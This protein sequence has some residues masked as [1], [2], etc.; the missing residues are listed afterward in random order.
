[1]SGPGD[2]GPA[3][4]LRADRALLAKSLGEWCYEGLL[5]PRV[6]PDGRYR[7]ELTDGVAYTFAATGGAFGWLRVDPGS[8]LREATG[9]LGQR[10]GAPA[11]DTRQL[12][13]DAAATIGI[14]ANT[15][16]EYLAELAATIAADASADAGRCERLRRLGHA[17]LEG[18]LTGHPWIVANKGR[19]GFAASDLMRYAPESRARFRLPWLAVQRGLAEFRA[20]PAL[21]EHALRQR[22]LD[23]ATRGR[24]ARRLTDLGLDPD[25]YVWLPVHPWQADRVID[26]RFGGELAQRRIVHLG[27]A[28]DEYLP[29]QS[30][31]T[32]T[33]M[34]AR[35][36]YD[37]KLPLSILNTSVWR[38]I[39]PH[40]T[41]G[42][43]VVTRWLHGLFTA[44]EY[45]SQQA[46]T[47][48]LGEVA[49]VTVAHPYLSTVAATPYR[50]L[51]TLGCIWREPVAAYADPDER[52]RS[53]AALLHVDADGRALLA[54]LVAGSGQSAERW[55][56]ALLEVLLTPILYVLYR[57]GLT[58]NPHGQNALIGYGPDE[59]PRRLY[60]KDFIDDVELSSGHLPERAPEPDGAVEMMPRKPPELIRQHVVDS[61]LIGFLRY[62]APLCARQVGLPEDRFWRLTR[63]AVIAVPQRFP[64]IA[65][66]SA[67]FDLL[68][69]RFDRYR[70]NADRLVVT[71]YGDAPIRHAIGASGTVPNPL[72]VASPDR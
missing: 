27:T 65:E 40:C 61:V 62:L 29:Q 18:W 22:E 64:E 10:N 37:V 55:V 25:S 8:V 30:I 72:Y 51:G 43:P 46:R 16:A 3:R 38:G 32:V 28:G 68:V 63:E 44:D 53:L 23:A 24:F 71:G 70:L 19:L 1:M 6:E 69:E 36:R 57:Y 34:S 12:A 13:V 4:W 33:N 52:V 14:A 31:R 60:L 58:F 54:E 56:S 15:L 67:R 50:H 2:I 41:A 39:P 48:F 9:L 59:M 21:S 66:R 47:V 5:S 17:E 49:S 42:G 26:G 7:V 20:I 45:L 35:S 11:T